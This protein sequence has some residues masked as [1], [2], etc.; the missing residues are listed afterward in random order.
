M[1]GKLSLKV[2]PRVDELDTITAAVEEF[3]E[4]E[5]W[6]AEL[7]FQ[8]NLVLEELGLNI[9]N[10]GQSEKEIEIAMTSEAEVLTIEIMD[11]GVPFDPLQD[12]PPAGSGVRDRGA[13]RGGSGGLS[14][15]N[16][17]GRAVLSAGGGQKPS[18]LGQEESAMKGAWRLAATLLGW[19]SASLWAVAV[20]APEPGVSEE[21][22]LFGQSAA[23]HEAN[24]RVVSAQYRG[25]EDGSARPQPRHLPSRDGAGWRMEGTAAF[26]II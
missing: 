3:G 10:H 5:K 24:R 19:A 18:D 8:V 21:R 20:P 25:G 14:G 6:P 9:M 2:E 4:A 1:S 17:D 12:A 26:A 15:A 11:N 7:V 16:H 22:I 23:F 13:K